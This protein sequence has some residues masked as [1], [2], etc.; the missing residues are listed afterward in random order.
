MSR[1][2]I[3]ERIYQAKQNLSKSIDLSIMGI[4][5][6]DLTKKI[7]TELY[8]FESID[9]SGNMLENIPKGF[10]SL[11]N[12]KKLSLAANYLKKISNEIILIPKLIELDLRDNKITT[13]PKNIKNLKYIKHLYLKGNSLQKF[14]K[15]LCRLTTLKTLGMVNTKI[16]EIPSDIK[17]LKKL[18]NLWIGKNKIKKLPD[19]LFLLKN[20]EKISLDDNPLPIPNKIINSKDP[21]KIFAYYYK[22]QNELLNFVYESKLVIVGESQAGKTSLLNRL[23]YN[24]FYI[25]ENKTESINIDQWNI[26]IKKN[27]VVSLNIWD[28]GGQDILYSLH[29]FFLTSKCIYMIV[30]D[31]RN[32]NQ[33]KKIEQWIE[34]IITVNKNPK[35]LLIMNKID[36]HNASIDK[37]YFSKLK[38]EIKY[39]NIS[40]KENWNIDRV[41]SEIVGILNTNEDLI[42]KYNKTI[43]NVKKELKQITSPYITIKEFNK[44][45]SLQ[46]VSKKDRNKILKKFSE[47]GY[48]LVFKNNLRLKNILILDSVWYISR[49]YSI[50]NWVSEKKRDGSF[51]EHDIYKVFESKELKLQEEI[52]F[53]IL[54]SLIHFKLI[55]RIKNKFYFPNLLPFYNY[56]INNKKFI[57]FE[58]DNKLITKD[59]FFKLLVGYANKASIQK[60]YRNMIHLYLSNTNVYIF[61][62]HM[63]QLI[64]YIEKANT[65]FGDI[66][67]Y[68]LSDFKDILNLESVDIKMLLSDKTYVSIKY[69]KF[70]QDNNYDSYISPKLNKYIIS[71]L[72]GTPE[73]KKII[74]KQIINIGYVDKIHTK[75]Y[76]MKIK[77]KKN[78]GDILGDQATKNIMNYYQNENSSELINSLAILVDKIKSSDISNKEILIEEIKD[79]TAD[80][81]KLKNVLEPLT[82][83]GTI[84]SSVIDVL[85]YLNPLS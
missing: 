44:L 38:A 24:R 74:E 53:F 64:I 59:S 49:V 36:E 75:G 8:F 72:L 27:K 83:I 5:E 28:F 77:I 56:D 45:Y 19:E 66:M 46:N 35:I 73:M 26:A 9:L 60:F 63:S 43:L 48:I 79:N 17:N 71:E 13:I 39:I 18:K 85:Q 40:C 61:S 32:E 51:T 12:L 29:N 70:L 47:T 62:N 25:D 50:I 37:T 65:A 81:M 78:Y 31:S 4:S 67:N 55:F 58:F 34:K 76:N 30:W 15:H 23:V 20:L 69:L 1:K 3:L 14:Y 21:K 22:Y 84:S 10:G 16:T 2:D 52:I 54:D 80:P 6:K 33:S 7:L 82:N 42:V 41:K 11:K 57:E 68:I